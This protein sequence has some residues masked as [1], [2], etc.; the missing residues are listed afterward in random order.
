MGPK[1]GPKLKTL[2]T[3]LFPLKTEFSKIV[4]TLSLS[5]DILPL[6]QILAE[7]GNFWG[8]YGPKSPQNGPFHGCCIA[9]KQFEIL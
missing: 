3:S 8:N 7:S 9:M 4:D 2:G 5:R 6:V 1:D